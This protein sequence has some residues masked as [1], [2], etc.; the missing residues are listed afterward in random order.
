VGVVAADVVELSPADVQ[1]RRGELVE[2][3]P[4]A[5]EG[6]ASVNYVLPFRR[7]DLDAYWKRLA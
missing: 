5:I 7:E 3:L 4:D 2:L 1:Q 6:G